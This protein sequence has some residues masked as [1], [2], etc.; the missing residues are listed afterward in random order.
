MKNCQNAQQ[1]WGRGPGNCGTH[2]LHLNEEDRRWRIISTPK[3][4]PKQRSRSLRS[5]ASPLI[6]N[7]RL[8][9]RCRAVQEPAVMM[10]MMVVEGPTLLELLG[11]D[12]R[13]PKLLFLFISRNIITN[14]HT[15]HIKGSGIFT[16]VIDS[17]TCGHKSPSCLMDTS[18][19]RGKGE[20]SAY[21][22]GRMVV[23]CS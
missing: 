15:D 10:M 21:N 11:M 2:N 22:N 18:R 3:T 14:H 1:E 7:A 4:S 23:C 8:M 12:A 19:Y 5:T 6:K 20:V 16:T 13:E 9:Q 17:S